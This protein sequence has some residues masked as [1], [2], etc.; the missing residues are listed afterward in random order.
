MPPKIL[1][2]D[3]HSMIRKGVKVLCERT[4]GFSE[5]GEVASCNELM[6]E[7]GKKEY[8]HL[9][10]DI[11]L[12]DGSSLEVLP[13]IR[14]VYPRLQIAVLTM[15]PTAV[16]SNVLR[17]YGVHH[18][19]HK[20]AHEDD[21]SRQLRQFFKSEQ[22]ARVAAETKQANPFKDLSAREL[23][24]LHYMLRGLGTKE[25]SENLNLTMS[26]I[27]TVKANIFLKT[28]TNNPM[29]LKELATAYNLN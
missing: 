21:T 27:S 26:T 13:N 24:I 4:L 12:S 7:L 1:L 3:D 18:I 20:A 28:K 23:E 2:A 11:N 22:P 15:Q 17:K 29:E 25:I 5:V 9:L 10:L 8:T 19:I 14:R 6:K 16:Y